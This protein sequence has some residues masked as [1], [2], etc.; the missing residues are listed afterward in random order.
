M[1]NKKELIKIQRRPKRQSKKS[2]GLTEQDAAA[3]SFL[4]DPNTPSADTEILSVEQEVV[5]TSFLSD[6]NAPPADTEILSVE[7]EVDSKKQEKI[8][9]KLYFNEETHKSIVLFQSEENK[10]ERDQLYVK[11]IMPAFEKLVENLINIYKF[12]SMHDTYEDLKVDCVNFLFETIHKFDETRGSNAFSYF[13]VVAKNWLIIKTKQKAQK[14]KR[15]VSLDD[16]DSLSSYDSCL[17]E[18]HNYLPFKD[19]NLESLNR[20]E[21]VIMLYDIRAKVK[22]ENELSCINSIITIFENLDEIDLLNKSAVLLYMRELS[23]LTPKQMTTTMQAIKGYYKKLK[24]E[25]SKSQ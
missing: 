19:A 23:G 11:K 12:T 7:Q 15:L 3:P 1:N 25:S 21:L 16:P 8:N 5:T 14:M 13:N 10:K 6:P 22:S 24:V 9:L 20:K 17:I 18:E 2:C 4:A